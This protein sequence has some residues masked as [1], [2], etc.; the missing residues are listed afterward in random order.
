M[1]TNRESRSTIEEQRI[2]N[3]PQLGGP[4]ATLGLSLVA[5]GL[6]PDDNRRE[7]Q[8]AT[9]SLPICDYCGCF[10]EETDQSCAALHDGVCAP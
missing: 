8:H 9:D 7:Q 2:R 10:I 5:R 3:N 1:A 4:I 6:L